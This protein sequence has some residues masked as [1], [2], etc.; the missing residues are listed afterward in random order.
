MFRKLLGDSGILK[1]RTNYNSLIVAFCSLDG[2]YFYSE[3]DE[4]GDFTN[5]VN[6]MEKWSA[7]EVILDGKQ[8]PHFDLDITRDTYDKSI[9][10]AIDI[11]PHNILNN[12]TEN[13]IIV[14]KRLNIE[15]SFN[16]III[17]DSSD[18]HKYSYHMIINNYYHNNNLEAREFFNL[19]IKQMDPTYIEYLDSGVYKR[20]QNF[21][22]PGSYKVSNGKYIRKKRYSELNKIQNITVLDELKI[23]LINIFNFTNMTYIPIVL[24]VNV[25]HEI[26]TDFNTEKCIELLHKIDPDEIF[27]Y[28]ETRDNIVILRRSKPSK[29]IICNRIH[30]SENPY[31]MITK[32]GVY[33]NC[34]RSK[35]NIFLGS[36]DSAKHIEKSKKEIKYPINISL[37]KELS[38]NI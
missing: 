13:I 36:L 31:L 32:D 11:I 38:R 19:V 21:R 35:N 17:F 26:I 24:P 5:Y 3:F 12:L 7:H 28:T 10:K 37:L 33:F 29:C 25:E 15:I 1:N 4:L 22:M 27:K 6:R 8:K 2:S 34:R 23:G 30:T 16:D 18:E 9:D 14:L 20:T